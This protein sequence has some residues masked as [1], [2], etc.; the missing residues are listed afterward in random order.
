M[1]LP[2]FSWSWLGLFVFLGG[3]GEEVE[4]TKKRGQN[5]FLVILVSLIFPSNTAGM[6]LWTHQW[7]KIS[8]CWYVQTVLE[9]SRPVSRLTHS[10]DT[11]LSITL[12]HTSV[13]AEFTPSES[14]TKIKSLAS[15][16]QDEDWVLGIRVQ[17]LSL[18]FFL[19]QFYFLNITKIRNSQK[20]LI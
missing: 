4:G 20:Y 5:S 17:V 13:V 15:P 3:G 16:V 11:T 10:R 9:V 6:D 14:K 1:S 8:K 19:S 7:W 12:L 2:F 18:F